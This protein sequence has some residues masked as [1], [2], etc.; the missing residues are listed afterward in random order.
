VVDDVLLDLSVGLSE[1]LGVFM[2]GVDTDV[3]D[4]GD[5]LLLIV[6]YL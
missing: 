4:G 1:L 3:V 6:D 2:E 5:W